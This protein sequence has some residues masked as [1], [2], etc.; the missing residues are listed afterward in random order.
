FTR[1]EADEA[2]RAALRAQALKLYDEFLAAY[3]ETSLASK[4]MASKG[5][6]LLV[7]GRSDDATATFN[8]LA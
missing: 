1:I 2:K 4:V 8:E 3:P 5:T 7:M 6:L